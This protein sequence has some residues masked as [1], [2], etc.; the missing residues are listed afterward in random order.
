MQMVDHCKHSKN[1]Y[2]GKGDHLW[3]HA[4]KYML[5][6]LKYMIVIDHLPGQHYSF[7]NFSSTLF[8]NQ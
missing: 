8:Q 2:D 4:I 1:D 7:H 6:V 5:H 3:H